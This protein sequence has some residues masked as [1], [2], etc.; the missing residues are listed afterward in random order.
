[1]CSGRIAIF[2]SNRKNN[3]I[4]FFLDHMCS[5]RIAIFSSNQKNN[6]ILSFTDLTSLK[7]M[8]IFSSIIDHTWAMGK[9]WD[10]T[11]P[12]LVWVPASV[13]LAGDDFSLAVG[14]LQTSTM[15]NFSHLIWRYSL[16]PGMDYHR[17][18]FFSY[19]SNYSSWTLSDRKTH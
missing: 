7:K 1:M 2:S 15:T 9:M 4:L 14:W 6:H 17:S 16:S 10:E 19:D 12:V 13:P 11:L 5:G 18:P 8:F 3:H